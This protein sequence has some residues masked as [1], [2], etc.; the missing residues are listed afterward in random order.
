MQLVSKISAHIICQTIGISCP[1]CA[2]IAQYHFLRKA[3]A[4][5]EFLAIFFFF[6]RRF[7]LQRTTVSSSLFAFSW[8]GPQH[9]NR[10]YNTTLN[11]GVLPLVEIDHVTRYC[12]SSAGAYQRIPVVP[13]LEIFAQ[14]LALYNK[15][16]RVLLSQAL[17]VIGSL[18]NLMIKLHISP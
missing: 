3:V 9:T 4:G 17:C 1:D 8:G 12:L 13:V 6:W 7:Y 10:H 18:G 11:F 5:I 2:N 15:N 16:N 14:N